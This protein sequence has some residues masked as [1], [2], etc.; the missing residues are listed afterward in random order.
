MELKNTG[1]NFPEKHMTIL[2]YVNFNVYHNS[3]PFANDVYN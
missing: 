1:K 3:V 2:H